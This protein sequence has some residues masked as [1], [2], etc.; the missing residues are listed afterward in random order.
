MNNT[1]FV[2]YVYKE[3]IMQP[4]LQ[5]IKKVVAE[6]KKEAEKKVV[7]FCMKR[8]YR[9]FNI[10]AIEDQEE[11]AKKLQSIFELPNGSKLDIINS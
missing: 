1:Y 7:R 4:I 8:L 9:N 6:S 5:N 3:A 2:T 11:V 10:V